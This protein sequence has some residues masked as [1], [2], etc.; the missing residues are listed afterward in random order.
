L[1]FLIDWNRARKR[2][3]LPVL[4]E[5]AVRILQSPADHAVGHRGFLSLGGER[6]VYNT[7]E[8]AVKTPLRYGEPLHEMI[9]KECGQSKAGGEPRR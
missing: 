1:V 5:T 9:G 8:Q 4:N 3:R 2:L 6:L 7:L